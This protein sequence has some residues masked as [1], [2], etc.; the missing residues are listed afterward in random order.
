[1][2]YKII[3]LMLLFWGVLSAQNKVLIPQPT[4]VKF[5]N[6]SFEITETTTFSVEKNEAQLKEMISVFIEKIRKVKG[7]NL[8]IKTKKLSKNTIHF[9]KEKSGVNGAYQIFSSKE[10]ILVKAASAEGFANAIATLRQLLPSEIE[11]EKIT[12]APLIIP[13]VTISD[14]PSYQWRGLMLDVA[15]HFF[16]KE[17]ILKTIDR[18]ALLKL[19]VLHL[20]LIDNEGWRIEIKKYPKLTQVGAWRVNQE[21]KNWNERKT[22]DPLEKG[23]YGGF[24]TQNDIKEMVAYALK[25]GITIVPEVELPAHTMS[26]IAA[27]PELSCHGNPIAVPSGGVWP[28]TDIYCP[29]KE[30]TFTFLENVID[31]IIALFPSQYIHIGG[32]EATHTEWEKCPFCNERMQKENLKNVHQLQS[33]F[34]KR[35]DAYLKTKKKKLIGWDEILEGGLP[36]NAIVMNWRGV[37]IAQKIIEQGHQVIL[38]SNGYIDQYQGAPEKEPLAIGGHLPLT[39]LYTER[40]DEQKLSAQQIKNV[41]GVQ[42]NLWAEYIGDEKHSE[43]MLFPRLLAVAE[44]AWN[45]NE[46]ASVKNF[47]SKVQEMLPRLEKMDINYAKS[48]YQITSKMKNL[49][50]GKIQISLESEV[51]NADI[52]FVL[53]SQML[54]NSQPYKQPIEVSETTSFSAGIFVDDKLYDV[55]S[56]KVVFHKAVGKSVW[57]SPKYHENYQGQGDATLT[58]VVRGSKNFH[59]KQWLGWQLQSPEIVIDLQEVTDINQIIIG[60]MENQGSAIYFPAEIELFVSLDGKNFIAKEKITHSYQKNGVARLQHFSFENVNEKCRFVKLKF[61]NTTNELLKTNDGWLFLDE[62]QIF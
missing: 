18:M 21:D 35:I 17:Y 56:D 19:N 12:A 6:G 50:N 42:A 36:Q 46:T 2:K 48:M 23:T 24:Y 55:H 54:K 45:K 13:A 41:L 16:P 43:Y 20:H 53:N 60:A 4:S 57:F 26:A 3:F 11:S 27:Y 51:P 31:E 14:T 39:R 28:I 25:R 47:V 62:I 34:V 7:W 5:E 9:Q 8:K 52:R 33:Y 58:N 49:P 1:M 15:R 59:D 32:D 22:N 40:F 37:G 61:K 30:T 29:G 38:T 10:N 44:I